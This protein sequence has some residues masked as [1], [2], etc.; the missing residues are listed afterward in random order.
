[1]IYLL[2]LLVAI[3][4]VT[5]LRRLGII[6]FHRL[7]P[8]LPDTAKAN[9]LEHEDLL[10]LFD[11]FN[12]QHD[13]GVC[14]G[15]TLTWAQEAALELDPQFYKRLNLIKREKET[16]PNSLNA[17][18]E[19]IKTSQALSKKEKKLN[20]IKPFFEAI[21]LAQS[22][23]DYHEIYAQMIQQSNIDSIYKMIQLNLGKSQNKVKNLFSKTLS[24]ASPQEVSKFLNRLN[25]LLPIKGQVVVVCSS[26]EHT[27]GFKKCQDMMWLFMD[28][29]RLYEQS[30]EYPYLLVTSEEL[31]Q[32]LYKSLFESS[33]QLVL[34]CSFVAKAG[35]RKLSE[36]IHSLDDI[37]PVNETSIAINN[38][39]GYGALAI[40]IQT[41]DRSTVSA[42]LRLHKKSPIISQ[43]EFEQALFYA[44]ACNRTDMMNK[45]K[46]IP[47]INMNSSCTMKGDSPLGVACK[48]GNERIV[49]LLLRTQGIQVNT[50]NIKGMTP[51]MNACKS[52]Y[53]QI[54]PTLFELLLAAGADTTLTNVDGET[55]GAI[56]QKYDNQTALKA[57]VPQKN[58]QMRYKSKD[59]TPKGRSFRKKTVLT[60]L[61]SSKHHSFFNRD[62]EPLTFSAQ[63]NNFSQTKS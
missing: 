1:M 16:L 54:S 12:Y 45:L 50:K 20:E 3:S 34:H 33:P 11:K 56:A 19:K 9:A 36:R 17:I 7:I 41:D 44:A 27:V 31:C 13:D 5:L 24:L 21:C 30:E 52:S 35:Q 60:A 37:Y 43:S 2:Y 53:S 22:P 51:L 57:L 23:D 28:I 46:G 58:S 42:I 8:F 62:D 15:F 14:H 4:L 29:N 47:Q 63:K 48:Y 32:A 40:A 25:G 49:R 39:R 61:I 59:D 55:A 38:C 18:T 10:T 26:E 6:S